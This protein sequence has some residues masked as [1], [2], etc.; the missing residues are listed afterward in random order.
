M[1]QGSRDNTGVILDVGDNFTVTV[2][3]VGN[4]SVINASDPRFI[5]VTEFACNNQ[6][7]R[8]LKNH[9]MECSLS[10]PVV[11][12][13]DGRTLTVIIDNTEVITIGI[14]GKCKRLTP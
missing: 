4:V 10:T 8:N 11:L 7:R 5:C 12:S 14:M 9:Y 2:I 13:D 6:T 1:P 3:A